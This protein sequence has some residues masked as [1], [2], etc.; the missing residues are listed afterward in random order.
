VRAGQGVHIPAGLTGS[1]AYDAELAAW[2]HLLPASGVFT[3]LTAAR[4]HGLWLPSLPPGLPHFVAMGTVPGE[5]RPM[6]PQL[7]VVRHPTP[8]SRDPRRDLPLATVAE[9][10]LETA[11]FL[12]LLD[13][14][15]L[16]DSALQLRRTTLAELAAVAGRRRRGAPALRRALG[17]ADARSESA[18]E[19][20]LRMLHVVCGIEVEPQVEF[21]D[22]FGRFVARADLHVTGTRLVQEYDGAEHRT[23][24]R[25]AHDLR[26]ERGLADIGVTRRG[27][28]AREVLDQ[29]HLILGAADRAL[30]RESLTSASPWLR[31]VAESCYRPAGRRALAATV[32]QGPA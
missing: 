23:R 31:L 29:S 24:E 30:G 15:A 6:R 3:G 5:V 2:A 7:H 16:V 10:L 27:Y 25:Q 20:L 32:G 19:T 8:P 1:A 18:W 9:T 21:F 17:Y 13:L 4:L 22:E 28:V 12:P 11:R 26:R 14:V